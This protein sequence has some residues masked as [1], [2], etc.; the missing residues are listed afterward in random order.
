MSRWIVPPPGRLGIVAGL[1]VSLFAVAAWAA[2]KEAPQEIKPKVAK[3]DAVTKAI[4]DQ[5]GKV[6]VVDLWSDG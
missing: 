1:V 6:V 4:Q 5:K 2:D 3:L